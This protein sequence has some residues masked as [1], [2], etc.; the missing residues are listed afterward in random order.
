MRFYEWTPKALSMCGDIQ[1]ILSAELDGEEPKPGSSDYLDYQ[2]PN[3]ERFSSTVN[4]RIAQAFGYDD[5]AIQTAK[6]RFVKTLQAVSGPG[7]DPRQRK[8]MIDLIPSL[9]TDIRAEKPKTFAAEFFESEMRT[10]HGHNEIQ[11]AWEALNQ[12]YQQKRKK[13]ETLAEKISTILLKGMN[14]GDERNPSLISLLIDSAETTGKKKAL[15]HFFSDRQ[16]HEN[17]QWNQEAVQKFVLADLAKSKFQWIVEMYYDIFI[18]T[19]ADMMMIKTFDLSPDDYRNA[20]NNSTPSNDSRDP[21][22]GLAPVQNTRKHFIFINWDKLA[23]QSV[24]VTKRALSLAG[25][26]EKANK[27]IDIY[28]DPLIAYLQTVSQKLNDFCMEPDIQDLLKQY[29]SLRSKHHKSAVISKE[30][31]FVEYFCNKYM[32]EES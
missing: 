19:T 2:D 3:F 7:I 21:R 1:Q 27:V 32:Q 30:I 6:D 29:K 13:L 18:E 11:V 10:I 20:L 28:P 22:K 14:A 26:I 5:L 25:E 4:R 9:E 24:A 15:A 8:R 16:I 31:A 12:A 23:K 17:S